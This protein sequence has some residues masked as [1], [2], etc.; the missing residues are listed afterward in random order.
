MVASNSL[1]PAVAWPDYVV[2]PEALAFPSKEAE[3]DGFHWEEATPESFQ[4]DLD[5]ML[6]SSEHIST[7]EPPDPPTAPP[8]PLPDLEY[9]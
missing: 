2:T 9:G 5:A 8:A 4:A 7:R 3:M 1:E 6:A